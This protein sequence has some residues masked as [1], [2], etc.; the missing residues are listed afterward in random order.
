MVTIEL[1]IKTAGLVT[2]LTK[3]QKENFIIISKH[4]IAFNAE[5]KKHNLNQHSGN[6][7]KYGITFK[8]ENEYFYLTAIPSNKQ[9]FPDHFI[10]FEI[11]KGNY[12]IFVHQGAMQDIKQTL[13]HIYKTI[14][15]DLNLKIE[16]H[17]KKGFLHFEKYDYRFQW[18]N[19]KSVIEI[20]LPLKK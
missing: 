14:I 15:P 13:N 9:I 3:S 7:V 19:P 5:L 2:Q 4:W 16:D 17:E 18:N 12:E 1:N 20:Y 8:V 6:W 10:N 11:S